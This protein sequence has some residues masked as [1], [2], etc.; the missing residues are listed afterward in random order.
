MAEG[1]RPETLL[2]LERTGLIFLS[3]SQQCVEE[4]NYIVEMPFVQLKL[5]NAA[6]A[7]KQLRALF[8]HDLLFFPSRHRPWKWDDFE[9]M[10]PHFHT[11]ICRAFSELHGARYNHRF[12]LSQILRGCRGPSAML[13]IEVRMKA[14]DVFHEDSQYDLYCP[15]DNDVVTIDHLDSYQR[16]ILWLVWSNPLSAVGKLSISFLEPSFVVLAIH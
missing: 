16:W 4:G 1:E 6:V 3:K 11:T 8:P 9:L 12:K 14:F 15:C 5:I 7:H 10:L 13:D 2:Q